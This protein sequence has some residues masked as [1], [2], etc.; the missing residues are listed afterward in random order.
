[1]DDKEV[2]LEEKERVEL[3]NISD[4]Q[5]PPLVHLSNPINASKIPVKLTSVN[6]ESVL[7]MT[8]PQPVEREAVVERGKRPSSSNQAGSFTGIVG[9]AARPQ[10]EGA[11]N[12]NRPPKTRTNEGKG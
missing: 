5:P 7:P 6:F 11:T 3:I 12:P 2:T 1:L 10:H 4:K 9:V 8:R